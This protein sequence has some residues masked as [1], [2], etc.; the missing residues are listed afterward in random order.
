MEPSEANGEAKEGKFLLGPPTFT[1][2]GN[3]RFRC[4]ETGHE[5]P[6]VDRES[7]GRSKRCRAALIDAALSLKKAPLNVFAQDPISKSKLICKLTGDA[8][9]KSEEHIWKHING[10]RF[11]NK[12]DQKEAGTV[13]QSGIVEKPKK[14]PRKTSHSDKS[15]SK[16]NQKNDACED[17]SQLMEPMPNDDNPDEPDFW[18]PPVGSRWDFD[19]GQDRWASCS[20]SGEETDDD[21][22]RG[23]ENGQNGV[24]PEDLS[25]RTKR[26]SIAVGPSSYASRKKKSKKDTSLPNGN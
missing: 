24:E 3:G 14:A 7:Y 18:I 22:G 23:E 16:N 21:M 13:T 25:M 6:A 9:N 1:D 12:L 4:V 15:S 20:S 19:D 2:I 10:K 11:L 5:L 8:I 17:D 26:M